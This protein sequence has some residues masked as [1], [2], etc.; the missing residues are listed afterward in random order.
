LL[1]TILDRKQSQLLKDEKETLESLQLALA[2]FEVR[3][4][5]QKALQKSLRQLDELFL[6]V[7]VGEF[8]SGKSAFIN[9]LLG[10]RFLPE[11]VTPTT[12]QIHILDYGQASGR[13]VQEEG[14]LTVT[15]PAD[16]LKEINIVDTPGTNAI[17][18]RHEQLTQEFVPRSDLVIFVTSA[19]RPFTESERA[20]MERIREWGKKVIIVL[21]KIDLL[22]DQEVEQVL[23]F[24]QQNALALLGFTPEVFTVSS[25]LALKAKQAENRRERN[26]LWDVSRFE[27]V[28]TY[29]LKTLDEK[30][31]IRLK[32]TNPLGVGERLVADYLT[33]AQGRLDLLGEDLKAI[34]NIEAQL[35][36]YRTDMENDF[37][38]RMAD[39]EKVLLEMENRGMEYF[40]E[41]LRVARVFDLVNTQRIQA[42]FERKVIAETPYDIEREVQSLID[43]L[44][45]KDLR[46]WQATLEYLDRHRARLAEEEVLPG[47]EASSRAQRGAG[48]IIGQVGGPFEYNRRALLDSVGRAAKEVVLTYDRE[49]EARKLAQSVRDAV[50]GVALVEVGAVGL[51]AILVAILHGALLDF[52]GV[53]AGS[54][55]AVVGLLIIPA[56]RRRAKNDLREKLEDLRQNLME[57]MSAEFER[58]LGRSLQRLREAI[59]PY[60][61]FVRAEQQKLTRIEGELDQIRATLAQIRA[62]IE[63]L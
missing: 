35:E 60:T 51:G 29:I 38:Y 58:E 15:Y 36:L 37:R 22:E 57:S 14:V 18:R 39:V 31:R 24:I 40:D 44:V 47:R 19:D 21:N 33:S 5:D 9:A 45:E 23:G 46:Q 1:R 17:I 16:F 20:F 48:K 61:R 7:I 11:G 28:E 12:A 10:E 34:E 52:T 26:A 2:G 43:W 62:R 25:R 59:A 27:A 56:K 41:T 53:L 42:E 3:P 4:E 55:L 32:L 49:A 50:A 54:A 63:D 13:E 30:S 8:N 6:L